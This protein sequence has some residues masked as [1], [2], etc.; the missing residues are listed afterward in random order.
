M[1]DVGDVPYRAVDLLL[2]ALLGQKVRW[3]RRAV[4]VYD[5]AVA[6]LDA[7]GERPPQGL[8]SNVGTLMSTVST[9]GVLTLALILLLAQCANT[10]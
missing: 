2:I 4:D 3:H 6:L 10:F 8:R 5:L 1:S 9:L 7:L